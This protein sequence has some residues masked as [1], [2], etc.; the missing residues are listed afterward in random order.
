MQTMAA[1]LQN[2]PF[3]AV[4][5][6]DQEIKCCQL[7]DDTAIFKK[8]KFQIK[9]I[10]NCLNIFSEA[11][12]LSLN[13]KQCFLVPLKDCTNSESEGFQVKTEV[14]YLGINI[15]KNQKNRAESNFQP[16]LPKIKN[17]FNSW[18]MRDFSLKGRVLL[19]KTE[20]LSRVVY[21]AKAVHV[22]QTFI[23]TLIQLYITLYG[24][25]SLMTCT[26]VFFPTLT[27]MEV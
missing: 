11:S 12:G 21:P 5:I 18:L 2:D 20:G 17:K 6:L 13:L 10:L 25:K 14:T 7:A 3:E 27:K 24:G 26:K 16:I 8:N 19:S 4:H 23:K 1:H 9:K 22:P 15:T